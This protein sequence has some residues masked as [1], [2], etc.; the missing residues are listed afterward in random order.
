MDA[1]T[2]IDMARQAIMTTAILISPA[3]VIALVVGCAMSLLQAVTQVQDQA[4]SFIP[5]LL[6]VATTILLCLPWMVEYLVQYAR[7]VIIQIPDTILGG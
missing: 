1:S 3:L 6:A 2:A 7:Q 5:K 4:I